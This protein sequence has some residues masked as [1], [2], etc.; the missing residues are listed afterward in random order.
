MDSIP[1][2]VQF[3]PAAMLI[4]LLIAFQGPAFQ[5]LGSRLCLNLKPMLWQEG[6]SNSRD[7]L[8]IAPALQFKITTL[9]N[10]RL[11]P[12]SRAKPDEKHINSPPPPSSSPLH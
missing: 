11:S 6:L 1:P 9:T 7:Y 5:D 12:V 10:P 4:S 8:R 3:R 2:P